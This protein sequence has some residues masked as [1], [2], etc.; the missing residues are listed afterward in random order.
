MLAPQEVFKPGEEGRR[1]GEVVTRGGLA[2]A[3]EEE[4][5]EQKRRRRAREKERGR[6]AEGNKGPEGVDGKAKG[7]K[8]GKSDIVGQLKKGGAKVIDRKGEIRDVDGNAVRVAA[9]RA[10]GGNFKL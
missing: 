5:R 3:R 2:V 8:A 9:G 10:G 7:K 4:T 1:E 6:K